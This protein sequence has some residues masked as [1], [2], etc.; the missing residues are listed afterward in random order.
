MRNC[1]SVDQYPAR[2]SGR[3]RVGPA[4]HSVGGSGAVRSDSGRIAS[5][6]KD[7]AIYG[8][9]AIRDCAGGGLLPGGGAFA[10]DDR[11]GVAAGAAGDDRDLSRLV[12]AGGGVS[13]GCTAA[14][15]VAAGCG[16]SLDC[17]AGRGAGNVPP[18]LSAAEIDQFGVAEVVPI[19]P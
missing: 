2:Y 4:V 8:T 9:Y 17:A 15:G 19:D 11:P 1:V 12:G 10:R 13:V 18:C 5:R 14:A 6:A 3:L 7:R 16:E